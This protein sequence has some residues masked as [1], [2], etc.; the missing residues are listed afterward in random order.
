[1]QDVVVESSHAVAAKAPWLCL[2]VISKEYFLMNP[3]FNL[4]EPSLR[5]GAAEKK[6]KPNNFAV[7]SL[8]L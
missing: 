5:L 2:I 1:M 3:F 8:Q 6:G 7:I 4:L